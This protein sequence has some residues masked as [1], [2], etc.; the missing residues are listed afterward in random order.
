SLTSTP[1]AGVTPAV[2][3]TGTATPPPTATGVAT[4]P[5]G[6]TVSPTSAA[7]A[8]ATPTLPAGP[9][10]GATATGSPSATAAIP[11]SAT[12]TATPAP[13]PPFPGGTFAGNLRFIAPVR[14]LDTRADA[15]GPIGINP[16][17]TPVA[18]GAFLPNTTR[19]FRL[20]GQT[21][22]LGLPGAGGPSFTFPSQATGV[23]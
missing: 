1:P 4:P 20:S 5:P 19:R 23:L 14:I 10:P 21:F 2:T 16:D 3:A 13:P 6:A 12:A 11:P 9:T 22:T 18:A 17:G 8:T 7:T 15:G